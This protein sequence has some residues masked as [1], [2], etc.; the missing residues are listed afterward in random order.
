[1]IQLVAILIAYFGGLFSLTR[2]AQML[3]QNSYYPTRYLKWLKGEKCTLTVFSLIYL[4]IMIAFMVLSWNIALLVLSV[5]STT[6]KISRAKRMQNKSI[7]KLVYTA[8]VKRQYATAVVLFIVCMLLGV[9]IS[10]YIFIVGLILAF[11]P[12]VTIL[13]V[14]TLNA[15]MEKAVA[16]YFINDAKKMLKNHKNLKVI[17]VTGSYGKTSTKYILAEILNQ[18]F[19]CIYTP[20]SFNTPLGVVRTV[21]ENLRADTQIFITE[22]GAKNVGDIDEICRIASPD[23]AIITSVGPQHLD[24]FKNIENVTKTKFELADSVSQ[25]KGKIFLN[26]DNE[27]I[28]KKA[29]EY[30]HTSYGTSGD[31]K[32]QN[33]SYTSS[34]AEFDVVANGTTM[35]IVTKLLGIH[36]V[37]NITAAVAVALS[38]GVDARDIAFAARRLK[39]IS[40][41]LE[42]KKFLGG[43]ILLDDA[44]NANPKGSIE[45][46]KVLGSFEGYKKIIVT[47]GLVELGEKEYECNYNLGAAAADVADVIILVGPSRAVPLKAACDDKNF[48]GELS[49]VNSF[50]EALEIL[51]AKADD[52]TVILIENDLP[53]NYSK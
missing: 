28:N 31:V 25:K 7:K 10:K 13:L 44:Y 9:T 38:L 20:Q 1:M 48:N 12:A 23:I 42:M 11:A 39:P 45:A 43:A 8:R 50:A 22:M 49:I 21:R 30:E 51:K 29:S 37:E 16:N 33:V 47:P 14:R 52:K 18:K 17:G 26:T 27:Y 19:N 34:G 24:T 3:Q 15:P 6:L 36:N 40:H 46:V 4:S 35:H 32:Y 41:R 5:V 53:D 2:Q